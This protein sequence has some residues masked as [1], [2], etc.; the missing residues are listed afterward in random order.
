MLGS[1][2]PV[3][4]RVEAF[5]STSWLASASSWGFGDCGCCHIRLLLPLWAGLKSPG[6]CLLPCLCCPVFTALSPLLACSVSCAACHPCV[7]LPVL[8]PLFSDTP[9]SMPT[10]VLDLELCVSLLCSAGSSCPLPPLCLK[11]S[12]SGAWGE[13]SRC[14]SKSNPTFPKAS[15]QALGSAGRDLLWREGLHPHPV[16][17]CSPGS[18]WP[19]SGCSFGSGPLV[20]T[21]VSTGR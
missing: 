5:N 18:Q 12:A 10:A 8:S 17:K 2:C 1:S 19:H 21:S 7:S 4:K 6:L 15:P 9:A 20:L 13:W 14:T 11:D 16:R 3:D